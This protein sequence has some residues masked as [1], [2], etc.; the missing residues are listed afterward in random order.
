MRSMKTPLVELAQ[1]RRGMRALTAPAALDALCGARAG[2][3]RWR[4]SKFALCLEQ[5]PLVRWAIRSLSV[6]PNATLAYELNGA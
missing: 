6:A 4:C 5:R 1:T 3:A 2:R